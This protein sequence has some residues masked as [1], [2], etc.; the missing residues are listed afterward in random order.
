[1]LEQLTGAL[2]IGVYMLHLRWFPFGIRYIRVPFLSPSF[3]LP[4]QATAWLATTQILGPALAFYSDPGRDFSSAEWSE[5]DNVLYGP[6]LKL[7]ESGTLPSRVGIQAGH[8]VDCSN[9]L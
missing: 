5:L 7:F 3:C 1:M 9:K 8:A 2:L 4:L 6:F